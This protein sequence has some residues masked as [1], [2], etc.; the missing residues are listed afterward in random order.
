MKTFDEVWSALVARWYPGD[1]FQPSDKVRAYYEV[2]WKVAQEVAA[3]RVLEIGVRAGYSAWIFCHANPGVRYLG[4]D[5]GMCDYEAREEYLNH[6]ES[7]LQNRDAL[8]WRIDTSSLRSFP[9][10][11][12][13][14]GGQAWDLVHIDGHHSY[15]GCLH[16]LRAAAA[17]SSNMLVDDYD[18]GADIQRACDTFLRGPVEQECWSGRVIHDGGLA[19]NLLLTNQRKARDYNRLVEEARREAMRMNEQEALQ[20]P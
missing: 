15:E 20:Q 6:A 11:P 10:A 18:T 12:R 4:I 19:G 9:W 5:N 13:G 8:L 14:P 1:S 2:K 7:I 16:D 3:T 17:V